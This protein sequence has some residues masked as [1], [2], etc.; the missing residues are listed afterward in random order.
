V[1]AEDVGVRSFGGQ[2]D[3]CCK[4]ERRENG[5]HIRAH[6]TVFPGGN[7]SPRVDL[8][9]CFLRLER[10]SGTPAA[11]SLA[12]SADGWTLTHAR[13]RTLA[14]ANRGSQQGRRLATGLAKRVRRHVHRTVGGT[15]TGRLT[16]SVDQVE[17]SLGAMK[18]RND[19]QCAVA[20][21][22]TRE[23]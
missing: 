20:E 14:V 9:E 21:E 19:E 6:K 22:A 3:S 2:S 5:T 23:V 16:A 1:R 7:N 13:P 17:R 12:R 4:S 11:R 10:G 15:V 18:G 8:A